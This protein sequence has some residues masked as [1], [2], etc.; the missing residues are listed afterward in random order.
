[1]WYNIAGDDPC[2]P[3]ICVLEKMIMI[4]LNSQSGAK[5]GQPF[6]VEFNEKT[7]YTDPEYGLL[8]LNYSGY[9][10]AASND[11]P[12][13]EGTQSMVRS[14]ISM[15]INKAMGTPGGGSYRNLQ[16]RVGSLREAAAGALRAKGFTVSQIVIAAL[17]PSESA[18]RL[19]SLRDQQKQIQAMSPQELAKRVEEAQ[20]QAEAA[21]AALTPDER[22]RAEAEARRKMEEDMAKMQSSI[23]MAKAISAAAKANATPPGAM[24]AA[25]GIA[26][27]TAATATTAAAPASRN[28]AGR[29]MA[30]TLQGQQNPQGIPA[31]C[32]NC[33]AKTKGTRFCGACG[34]KLM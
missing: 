28:P 9:A 2:H 16:E 10:D 8:E 5:L 33:G 25:A 30:A 23:D 7:F 19:I 18:L 31:F 12:G 17:Q 21:M 3:Q 1:M 29:P 15:E 4:N 24:A 14:L 32:P 22:M 13:D 11:R 34:T 20:K 6:R 26:A 27:T